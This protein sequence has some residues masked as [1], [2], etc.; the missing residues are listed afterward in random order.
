MFE[1]EQGAIQAGIVEIFAGPNCDYFMLDGDIQDVVDMF[2]S[3]MESMQ[4]TSLTSDTELKDAIALVVE[5]KVK[6]L[7]VAIKSSVESW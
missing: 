4:L 3:V 5:E 7:R 6:R 2:Y 1:L